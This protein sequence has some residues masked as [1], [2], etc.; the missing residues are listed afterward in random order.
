MLYLY[1]SQS[2]TALP[3]KMS[4]SEVNEAGADA[5]RRIFEDRDAVK[6]AERWVQKTTT[7]VRLC[8]V[9]T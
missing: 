9:D 7:R 5:N 3:P 4:L 1:L 6:E 8:T 2:K